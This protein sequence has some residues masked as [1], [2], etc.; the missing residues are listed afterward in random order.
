MSEYQRFNSSSSSR[1]RRFAFLASSAADS[2]VSAVP[3]PFI[4]S[5]LF[6]PRRS[7]CTAE[8]TPERRENPAA[9]L[10]LIHRS[11]ESSETEK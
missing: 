6:A 8:T 4:R 10:F 11:G 3:S 2:P 9:S 1:W 5:T 7:V